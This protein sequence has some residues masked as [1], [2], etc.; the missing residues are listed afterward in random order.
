MRGPGSALYGADAFNGVI[1]IITKT[2]GE[3]GSGFQV[4]YGDRQHHARLHVGQRA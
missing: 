2:P 4:G 1:N 3:G